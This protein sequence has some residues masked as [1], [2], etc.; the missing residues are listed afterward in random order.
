[1]AETNSD[2]Y[3]YTH[4]IVRATVEIDQAYS[5]N[6]IPV[7]TLFPILEKKS[8]CMRNS[9]IVPRTDY[10]E[11]VIYLFANLHDALQYLS[12]TYYFQTILEY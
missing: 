9:L 7:I 6:S 10:V 2:I 3:V 11:I 4:S 1:M 12:L 8:V 5:L